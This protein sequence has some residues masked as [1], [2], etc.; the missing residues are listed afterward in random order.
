M[1]EREEITRRWR[2][3]E[4]RLYPI[5]NVRPDLYEAAVRL[6]RSLND[7]LKSVPDGDALVATY[8]NGGDAAADFDDAGV[9]LLDV[10]P[11]IDLS[12]ARDAAYN[13]RMRELAAEEHTNQTLRA[14]E[15]AERA[16]DETVTIW[17]NGDREQW[18]PFR[19]VEMNLNTGFAVARS[20]EYNDET[21]QPVWVLEAFQ[22]DPQTGEQTD[23][24]P[25]APRREF[26]DPDTWRSAT[27]DLSTA[28][29]HSH[30]ETTDGPA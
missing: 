13:M 7:H 14:I 3:G 21:M 25:V 17:N 18:P 29:L 26:A 4:E 20:T 1:S 9:D 5:V 28:L 2:Q 11:D 6:V 30:K 23:E 24:R 16:G 19:S 27:T 10:S 22:L 15:R 8:S 12:L